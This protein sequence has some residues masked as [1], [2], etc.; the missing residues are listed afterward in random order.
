M[1]DDIPVAGGRET[2]RSV[3]SRHHQDRVA[4]H[5]SVGPPYRAPIPND[6]PHVGEVT[7]VFLRLEKC[8]RLVPKRIARPLLNSQ[9]GKQ[10]VS[11]GV[12]AE[13]RS[14]GRTNASVPT[15]A[16]PLWCWLGGRGKSL[17]EKCSSW[18]GALG[19]WIRYWKSQAGGGCG[20]PPFRPEHETLG[21]G[22]RRWLLKRV[23]SCSS[24][25]PLPSFA[26][27]GRARAPVPT[28]DRAL[29]FVPVLQFA[30]RAE[31]RSAG[32]T[33]ASVPTWLLPSLRLLEPPSPCSPSPRT[34]AADRNRPRSPRPLAGTPSCL[35]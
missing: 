30:E 20:I 29:P 6:N 18:G 1:R 11:S 8:L 3:K 32:R 10:G 2:A 24:H 33:N 15:R 12:R 25:G 23:R 14:A 19:S 4:D 26:R 22:T 35:S 17:G 28:P 34:H 13:L 21:W 16:I 31:L 27:L 7:K 5:A 9:F